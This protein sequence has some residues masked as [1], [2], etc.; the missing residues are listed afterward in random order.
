MKH[1]RTQ[2][3][4]AQLNA[5][6]YGTTQHS[7][8]QCSTAWHNTAQLTAAQNSTAERSIAYKFSCNSCRVC[9][10][11]VSPDTVASGIRMR[12]KH[13]L[14]CAEHLLLNRLRQTM[15]ALAE[16]KDRAKKV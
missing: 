3:S 8:A 13:S 2:H 4:T 7:I 11:A 12:I 16:Q 10:L 15:F 14:R 9:L 5:A 6:Q 1:N